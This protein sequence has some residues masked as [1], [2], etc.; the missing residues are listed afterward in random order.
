MKNSVF[1]TRDVKK[2]CENKLKIVFRSNA[3]SNGW[4]YFEGKKVARITVPKGRKPI[5]KG[6][7]K[8]MANQLKLSVDEF[9][10][11]LECPLSLSDYREKIRKAI[12]DYIL[13]TKF[14]NK[15]AE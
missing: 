5:A 8:S 3:E 11:L 14:R 13:A 4:F 6:L 1:S 7:Y 2:I 12:D 10:D 9:D 15:Q